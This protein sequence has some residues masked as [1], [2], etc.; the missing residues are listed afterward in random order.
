MTEMTIALNE[1]LRKM[2]VSLE[3]DWLRQVLQLALQQLIELEAEGQIGAGKYERTAERTTHRNGYRDREL[4]TRVGELNLRIP[5]LRQGSFFPGILEPRRRAERAVLAVIQ[6]A[7]I[8]GIST[9]KVD[10]LVQA[11]GLSGVD[12]SAVSRICQ[13]LDEVVEPF[14]QRPLL[15]RYP[16][17][18]LDAVYL[19]VRENQRIVSKA[20]V[21]AIGVRDSGEREVLGF[22][23][24][25][26]EEQAFWSE[27]LRSLV[28]RGLQGVQL[29]V[30]DAH[31]GLKAALTQVLA[32]ATWQRCRVHF[33]RNLLAHIPQADKSVVAAMVRTIFAQ[34]HRTAAGEQLA[35]IARLMKG[36]WPAAT[37]VLL[38][39]ERDVLAY[40]T[41]PVDH[42][43][44]LYSTNVLERLNREI[45][46]RTDVVQ[47][48]PNDPAVVR[49]VGAILLE[50][51]DEWAVERRYFG[52][53]S[54]QRLNDP[55]PVAEIPAPKVA[56]V[57]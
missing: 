29:V 12:K 6:E 49:L 56:P 39:A 4:A 54:M 23:V 7:Y 43:T 17:V 36:R 14:R 37:K 19:K 31:E 34:P 26:S 9:R 10:D 46:R 27:F 38:A 28:G 52:Q 55:T 11:L 21:I 32:G 1:H 47:V 13:G 40:M 50:I 24:G 53:T 25:A 20:V 5:K 15:G 8:E 51:S 42:W 44:R 57:R 33:M 18:W 48:F 30:S 45:R 35:E 41:F 22:A 2:G 3:G 16:Y